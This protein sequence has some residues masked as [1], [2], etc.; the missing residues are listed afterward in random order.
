MSD[1]VQRIHAEAFSEVDQRIHAAAEALLAPLLTAQGR[2]PSDYTSMEYTLAY[3]KAQAEIPP[4]NVVADETLV[5][6]IERLEARAGLRR[7]PTP[8]HSDIAK[9]VGEDRWLLGSKTL[10]TEELD[11]ELEKQSEAYNADK[12][13]RR[14]LN[15]D[16]PRVEGEALHSAAVE[17]LRARGVHSPT[18]DELLD[19]YKEVG[20]A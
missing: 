12:Q 5:A 1:A 20:A 9:K 3:E 15:L 11:A 2:N 19:A 17:L 18:A 14:D 16:A 10:T 8:I 4:A 6:R 7:T 13:L